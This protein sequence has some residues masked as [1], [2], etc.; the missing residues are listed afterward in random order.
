MRVMQAFEPAAGGV[1]AHVVEVSKGLI[2]RGH[3]VHV[4]SPR[5]P[6]ADR[7]RAVGATV[8]ETDLV[9]PFGANVANVRALR[10]VVRVLRAGNFDVIHC[11]GAKAG[12]IGR[13]A[14]RIAG[15]P[16]VYSPH[17]FVYRSQHLR[18]RRYTG[19]RT[20]VTLNIERL[21]GRITAAIV[22]VSHEECAAA[23][24]D[25]IIPADRIRHI[26]Y[27]VPVTPPETAMPELVAHREEGPLFGMVA[28]LREQKNLPGFVEACRR[29]DA[30]G[31][32]PRLAIVGDGPEYGEVQAALQSSGLEDRV[33][34]LPFPGTVAPALSGLD[35]FML[36]SLWEALPIAVLEAMSFGLPVIA[37]DVGG[38]SDALEDGVTGILVPR[39]DVDAV[40]AAVKRLDNDPELRASMG[41]AGL[42]KIKSHFGLDR[43]ID[44]LQA[45]YADVARP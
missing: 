9:A 28:N 5:A 43:M 27:G 6:I 22:G 35:V 15:V 2:E 34:L 41:R 32:L 44:S 33:L 38:T 10:D 4:M 26:T 31:A 7:L 21:M 17:C 20:F 3:D 13:V 23:R 40:V 39:G 30:D 45:L 14:A 8:T 1:P 24:D 12:V 42:E 29:L 37:S 11:H 36:P 19:A 16:S 18:G 25:R